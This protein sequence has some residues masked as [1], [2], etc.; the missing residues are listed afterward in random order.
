MELGLQ[1]MQGNIDIQGGFFFLGRGSHYLSATG[2]FLRLNGY[3]GKNGLT[4]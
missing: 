1:W 2:F 4:K 3:F